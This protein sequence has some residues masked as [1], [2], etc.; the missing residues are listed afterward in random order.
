MKNNSAYKANKFYIG[1]QGAIE[2]NWGHPTM[3][4]AMAQAKEM[5]EDESKDEVFIVEIRKVVRREIVKPP[6]VVED[7]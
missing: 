4:S 7:I 2:R 5:L 3:A 1:A 6:I